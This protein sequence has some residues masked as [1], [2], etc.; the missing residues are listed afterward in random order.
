[1]TAVVDC[2]RPT[3]SMDAQVAAV[4]AV[5]E[6]RLGR[7]WQQPTIKE[8]AKEYGLTPQ[9][10]RILVGRAERRRTAS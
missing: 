8:V 3:I 6:R 2:K 5:I 9:A 4:Q 1:V 7:R 10:L